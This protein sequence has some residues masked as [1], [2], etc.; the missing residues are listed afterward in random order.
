MHAGRYTGCDIQ[1]NLTITNH[2]GPLKGFT[3]SGCSPQQGSS[4]Y[5]RVD[6]CVCVCSKAYACYIRDFIVS[7]VSRSREPCLP[8]FFKCDVN[9]SVGINGTF[10]KWRR[11]THSRNTIIIA[12]GIAVYSAIFIIFYFRY[13][14]KLLWTCKRIRRV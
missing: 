10:E 4:N 12:S 6:R 8:P 5:N 2:S 7:I 1:S 14:N 13:S 9:I 11:D 3:R